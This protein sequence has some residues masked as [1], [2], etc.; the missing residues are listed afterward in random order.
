MGFVGWVGGVAVS[1]GLGMG[2]SEE[3]IASEL[4]GV[5]LVTGWE[6]VGVTEVVLA[7]GI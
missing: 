7:P 3:M 4:E 1:E 2:P 5:S 6:S